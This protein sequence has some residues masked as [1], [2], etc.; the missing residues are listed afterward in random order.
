VT[1][2]QRLPP[3]C[4][5][6]WGNPQ[7]GARAGRKPFGPA[8]RALPEDATLTIFI[9]LDSSDKALA[10]VPAAPSTRP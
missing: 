10:A 3:R 1:S 8:A 5:T 6:F 9:V 7:K 4:A 2:Q